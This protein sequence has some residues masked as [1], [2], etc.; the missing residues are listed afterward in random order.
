VKEAREEHVSSTEKRFV[1]LRNHAVGVSQYNSARR[2]YAAERGGAGAR[3]IFLGRG[4]GRGRV[5]AGTR[6]KIRRQIILDY[7]PDLYPILLLFSYG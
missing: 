5:I 6:P 1:L 2:R 7:Y 3:P 4:G